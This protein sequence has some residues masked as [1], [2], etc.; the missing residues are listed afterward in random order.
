MDTNDPPETPSSSGAGDDEPQ[1]RTEPGTTNDLPAEPKPR[2]PLTGVEVAPLA[3]VVAGLVVGMVIVVAGQWRL[4]CL[5]IGAVL[6]VGCLERLLLPE[7][8]VGLLQARSRLL[9]T[10]TLLAMA[11]GIIVLAVAVHT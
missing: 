5:V 11:V 3:V 10:L 8:R 1:E 7:S 2:Y 4:G 6:G 9:D